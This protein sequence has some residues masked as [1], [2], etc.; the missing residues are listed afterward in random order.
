MLGREKGRQPVSGAIREERVGTRTCAAEAKLCGAAAGA[1][2][3]AAAEQ[4]QRRLHDVHAAQAARAPPGLL[5]HPSSQLIREVK[6]WSP[7][8]MGTSGAGAASGGGGGGSGSS[9]KY[10]KR[11]TPHEWNGSAVA[12]SSHSNRHSDRCLLHYRSNP[13]LFNA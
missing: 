11:R 8:Q 12:H 1:P 4:D 13:C 2:S 3:V 7:T 6:E 5:L 10:V 9:G